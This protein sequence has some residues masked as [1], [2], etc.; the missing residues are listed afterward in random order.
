MTQGR[1]KTTEAAIEHSEAVVVVV[2]PERSNNDVVDAEHISCSAALS[3]ATSS[4][5]NESA[6]KKKLLPNDD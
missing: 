2:A 1:L 4:R 5:N 6:L 3:L